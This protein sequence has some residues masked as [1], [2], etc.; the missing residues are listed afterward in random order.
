MDL[1]PKHINRTPEERGQ[2]HMNHTIPVILCHTLEQ[3]P[4][5]AL[6]ILYGSFAQTRERPDSDIDLAVAQSARQEIDTETMVDISLACS[7]ATGREVQVRDLARAQG[8][9]LRQ[10]LTKGTV[11]LA[12]KPSVR[13]ELIIRMLDFI[14]DN[15]PP[16]AQDLVK[17]YDAQD[18]ISVNL[19]RAIQ[20]CVDL[21][22]HLIADRGWSA[23]ATMAETFE[24]LA[25]NEVVKRDAAE[26]LRRAVGFRN[27]S[28]HEY[29]KIDWERVY[30]MVTERLG[31]FRLYVAALTAAWDN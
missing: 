26:R 14:E 17:D 25:T 7:D 23:P 9:F 19:Q 5:I 29:E 16:R 3:F 28:V 24:T 8:V 18:I 27:I 10:V 13:A 21:G 15:V 4:D 12:R 20:L 1:R 30:K 6:A 2:H 11:L 31:D 22:A